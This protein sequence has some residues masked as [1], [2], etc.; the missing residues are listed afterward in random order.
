MVKLIN[1]GA[2]ESL[3]RAIR[4]KYKNYYY[5]LPEVL[6]ELWLLDKSEQLRKDKQAK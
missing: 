3:K 2:A 4:K 1:E 6:G 5:S